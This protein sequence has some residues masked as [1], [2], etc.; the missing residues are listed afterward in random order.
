MKKIIFNNYGRVRSGW[1]ILLA[2]ILWVFFT[3]LSTTLIKYTLP[4]NDFSMFIFNLMIPI[5]VILATFIMV[6]FVE[7]KDLEYIG[8]TKLNIYF[9]DLLVGFIIGGITLTIMF[10][11]LLAYG[12]YS[13]ENSL[14][15]PYLSINI[16]SGLILYIFV[17][18]S[19]EVFGRGYCVTL[20]IS[21][22]NKKWAALI[23]SS[24]IFSLM[25]LD[26]ANFNILGFINGIAIGMLFAYMY[27]KTERLWLPIGY[28]IAWDYF[29]GSIYGFPVSGRIS[30]GM[31]EIK[32]IK[33]DILTGGAFGPESGV[34]CTIL[35]LVGFLVV[36]KV[37]SKRKSVRLDSMVNTITS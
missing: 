37:Y 9:K 2:N 28:H 26:N 16:I 1:K 3:I 10:F 34:L 17:G 21:S 6:K 35:I 30:N 31:Y 22:G 13:F 15:Q 23:M 25:H 12:G 14:L 29:E 11:V 19:E 7:K 5:S 24:V 4:K 27:Y 33:E 8:L 20:L 18:I 32:L 36:W